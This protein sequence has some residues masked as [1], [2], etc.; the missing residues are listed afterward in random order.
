MYS[1]SSCTAVDLENLL[2]DCHES[3]SKFV[4]LHAPRPE[5]AMAPRRHASYVAVF[6]YLSCQE[7]TICTQS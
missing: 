1:L 3:N 4:T 2:H 6:C 7:N 5:S